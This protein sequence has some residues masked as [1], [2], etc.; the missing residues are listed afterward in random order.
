[1]NE[2]D[3]VS[4]L[5]QLILL[6][7]AEHK[8]EGLQLKEHLRETLESL[9]PINIIKSSIK[10]L[11]APEETK[12]SLLHTAIGVAVGFVVKKL[13]TAGSHN[14]LVKLVG[15]VAETIVAAKVA[16]NADGIQSLGGS[17]L[18]AIMQRFTD[19]GKK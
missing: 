18:S 17:I 2:P 6:K 14:P 15:I 5:K 1:M 13:L 10:E 16:N 9:K 12:P 4:A 8:E 3:A 7:E 19:P 11:T